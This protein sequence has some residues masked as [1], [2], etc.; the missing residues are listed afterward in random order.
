MAGLTIR[1][2][3]GATVFSVLSGLSILFFAAWVFSPGGCA[4]PQ[5]PPISPVPVTEKADANS[6]GESLAVTRAE[7]EEE[8]SRRAA[9]ALQLRESEEARVALVEE[10]EALTAAH[11]GANEQLN[12]WNSLLSSEGSEGESVAT[13]LAKMAALQEQ[14]ANLKAQL[15][16]SAEIDLE[17]LTSENTELKEKLESERKACREAKKKLESEIDSLRKEL[18]ETLYGDQLKPAGDFPA[19]DLPFLVNDPLQLNRRVR[20]VFIQLR[21]AEEEESEIEKLYREITKDGTVSAPHTVPFTVGSSDVT[22]EES[23]ILAEFLNKIPKG[24]RFLV[25]G[26]ASTDG[27]AKSNYELSS[28]R[29]SRVAAALA[30]DEKVSDESV[31]AVYFGQTKRFSATEMAPNRIVEVWPVQ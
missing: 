6:S 8:T 30:G 2:E 31:Q 25:V 19:L 15:E 18:D 12:S 22:A 29:A 11:S 28:K 1:N 10:L 3:V 21:G 13:V 20:P 27:D 16:E 4:R 26:Y 17:A 9:L 14:N 5:D 7:W 23:G 24:A